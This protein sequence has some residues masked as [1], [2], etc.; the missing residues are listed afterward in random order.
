MKDLYALY[1]HS[2]AGL[3]VMIGATVL[4]GI[5]YPLLV[6]GVAQVS[7]PWHANG[8]L[9]TS[10]GAHTTSTAEAVGSQLLGQVVDDPKLFYDRPSAA[11]DGYDPTS[12]YGSNL[13][14]NDPRLVKAVKAARQAIAQREG[15][16]VTAVPADAVTSSGSGLDPAIS[17]AYADLQVA[18]VA[19][20]NDLSESAVRRLVAENTHGRALGVLGAPYVNV[21]MLNL[22]VTHAAGHPAD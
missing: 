17:P 9:V 4:L 15:V 2:L 19:K 1:R 20:A 14:P 3:R 8:S 21:L 11:G 18:R 10:T 16:P 13:G 6:T 12:S 22:A 5:A 7:M